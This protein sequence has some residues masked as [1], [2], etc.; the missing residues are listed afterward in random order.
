M[1]STIIGFLVM[2]NPFALF[3]YLTPIMEELS[4]EKFRKVLLKASLIS[5]FILVVFVL[6]GKKIFTDFFQIDFE[7][8]RIFGG[9]ILFSFAYL[10]IVKGQRALLHMKEDLDDLASDIALPFMIG[11]GTISLAILMANDF[12]ATISITALIMIFT[13]SYL[14]IMGLRQIKEMMSRK[15]FKVAFDKTMEMSMRV[16]GF[17]IG[18]I[19]VDMVVV[20]IRNLMM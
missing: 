19:G 7:S 4:E 8:F 15:R 6:V 5:L 14:M 3:I 1:I 2:L 17:F 12:G 13:I 10:Y 18:A 11:A 16:M 9:I 20:G